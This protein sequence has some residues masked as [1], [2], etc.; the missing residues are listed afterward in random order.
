[1]CA[2]ARPIIYSLFMVVKTPDEG[3]SE[4]FVYHKTNLTTN[5]VLYK[6]GGTEVENSAIGVV[7][8]SVFRSES[9]IWYELIA[10]AGCYRDLAIRFM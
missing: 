4:L 1:M 8:G 2:H 6:V 9:R 7:K 10:R 5:R 3:S